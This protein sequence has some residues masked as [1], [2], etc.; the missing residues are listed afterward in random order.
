MVVKKILVVED[1]IKD[2]SAIIDALVSADM[3]YDLTQNC[4]DGLK[5]ACEFR[6]DAII[7]DRG[8]PDGDGLS[9]LS[10][11]RALDIRTPVLVL[12][13]LGQTRHRIEG[14]KDGADDYVPKHCDREELVLRINA[15]L[16]RVNP[17][18]HPSILIKG[19]FELHT[20]ARAAYW[21][22]ERLKL[23]PKEFDLFTLL[24]S[25][26]G[27]V[28]GLDEIWKTVWPDQINLGPQR[29]VINV[30]VNRLRNSIDEHL[31]ENSIENPI[32]TVR[33]HGYYFKKP[34]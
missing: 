2:Q 14:L 23:K 18:P 30:T 26:D 28:A 9:V 11:L 29:Q 21:R 1:D 34:E 20:K 33:N 17:E 25:L 4:A 8:L 31:K 27:E 32:M 19:E 16:R 12:S 6:Y 5:A 10:R 13:D 3:T 15:L 22:G 7:L 24:A